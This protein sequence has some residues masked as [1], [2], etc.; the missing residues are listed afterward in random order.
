MAPRPVP[1]PALVPTKTAGR[2]RPED[3]FVSPEVVPTSGLTTFPTRPPA[4]PVHPLPQPW[5]L[6]LV[7]GNNM[8]N[9]APVTL[10][11]VAGSSGPGQYG[12]SS[13][14]GGNP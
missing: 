12:A 11:S 10:D 14:T 13:P 8:R 2:A 9:V 1:P 6:P 5:T 4:G 7:S 3:S